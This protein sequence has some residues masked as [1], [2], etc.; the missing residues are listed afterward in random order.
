MFRRTCILGI[1]LVLG[2]YIAKCVYIAASGV[3]LA[4][5]KPAGVVFLLD[6]S[7]SN[8]KLQ[9]K[10]EDTI[11]RICK[12]L[13]SEDRAMIYI[14][15]EDTFLIY[16]ENPHKLN[17]VRKAFEEHGKLDA[18]SYGTA[19]G[20]A[21]KKAADDALLLKSRGYKPAI[22]VLG[23]LENEGD[24]K[25]QINWD[26]LPSN[27]EKLMHYIPD[28]SLAFLYAHP[29]KLDSAREKLKN[30]IP[31][32]QLFFAQEENA[33]LAVNRLIHSLGR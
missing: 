23:D 2:L 33:D 6:T 20:L 30:V 5:F 4:E 3:Q 22:V 17:A 9:A 13:D 8:K 14:V 28:L 19:Y 15:T 12:R 21:L 11:L 29:K 25:K 26:K 10:Q 7:A 1:I 32:K 27:M 31:D 16:D 18:K 24:I